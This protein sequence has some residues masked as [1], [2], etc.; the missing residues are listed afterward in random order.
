M[1]EE[2]TITLLAGLFKREPLQLVAGTDYPPARAD[3]VH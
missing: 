2:R 1:P 3:N